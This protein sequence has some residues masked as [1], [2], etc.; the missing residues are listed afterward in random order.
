MN[1]ERFLL[2]VFLTKRIRVEFGLISERRFGGMHGR[3]R[4]TA[5]L[6]IGKEFARLE[7]DRIW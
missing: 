3:S 5:T 6:L 2:G 4:S 7:S 1:I